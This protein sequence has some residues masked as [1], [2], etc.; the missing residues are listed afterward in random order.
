MHPFILYL[1]N[2]CKQAFK[3]AAKYPGQG[4]DLHIA[5]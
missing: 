4:K 1:K 2:S 3:D 5:S